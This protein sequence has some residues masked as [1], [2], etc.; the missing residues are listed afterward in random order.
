MPHS[1]IQQERDSEREMGGLW[2]N[3]DVNADNKSAGLASVPLPAPAYAL[4][5]WDA[6]ACVPV[7][8]ALII[9]LT[10][11]RITG[12]RT[13]IQ[14]EG[15]TLGWY[16]SIP[17]LHRSHYGL[18]NWQQWTSLS[19][20][21]LI[22]RVSAR[23]HASMYHRAQSLLILLPFHF[24]ALLHALQY[25]ALERL[26]LKGLLLPRSPARKQP[27]VTECSKTIKIPAQ[28][29]ANPYSH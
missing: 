9:S 6:T 23:D 17:C 21:S 28:V 4:L 27:S 11:T 12:G 1:C 13:L 24:S 5:C 8:D 18:S 22:R 16:L 29:E 3:W 26:E 7:Q 14:K 25:P 10:D 2:Q 20:V 15:L 19:S